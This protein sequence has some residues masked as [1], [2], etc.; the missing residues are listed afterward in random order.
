[1]PDLLATTLRLVELLYDAIA[2]AGAWPVFLDSL[3]AQVR[4]VA[5]GL[6]LTEP[7]TDATLFHVASELDPSWASKYETH[8]KRCDPRRSHIKALPAGSVFIGSAL[9]P[10]RDLI[11]SEFYNDF[12]RPQ[13]YFQI[14]GTVPLKSPEV[15]AVLRAIRP[16]TAARFG[17]WEVDLLKSLEPHLAKA[18]R[19]H[20]LLGVAETRREEAAEVLDRLPAGVLLLDASGQ[21]VG[22]NRAGD[23]LITKGD[24]L[25]AG[26]DGIRA[27]LPAETL[28]LRQ[29]VA[30]AATPAAE[31]ES[32]DGVLNIHRSPPHR[33]LNVLVAPLRGLLGHAGP[34]AT[35]ALFVSDPERAPA[36]SVERMRRWL[37]L[38][39]AEAALV[40]ELLRGLRV[41][42]AADV[43]QISTN[44]ARTQLKRVLAKTGT[45]RQAE[46]LRLALAAPAV[47][48]R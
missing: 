36:T 23:A 16:K 2:D 21:V 20:Q 34:R 3:A 33:P 11:R 40:L 25:R 32:S 14:L 30:R 1:M 31:G 39:T 8:F 35:V 47:L 29:M 38:T 5:P 41:E 44:T 7:A 18:L 24:G 19:L 17:P 4:G 28:A 42:E 15:V 9:L 22:A 12:L 26:R 46:L 6:Y 13:G 48:P 27:R 43:L 10:D 37:G 45:G